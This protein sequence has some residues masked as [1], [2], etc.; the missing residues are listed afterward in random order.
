MNSLL[1]LLVLNKDCLQVKPYENA[2]LGYRTPSG[3]INLK[4]SLSCKPVVEKRT[5]IETIKIVVDD[6]DARSNY[7][8]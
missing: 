8:Q 6:D 7:S 5:R 1:P 4:T 2:S 3:T